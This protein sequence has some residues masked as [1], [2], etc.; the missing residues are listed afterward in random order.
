MI[1]I[2]G[3]PKH[4]VHIKL[5]MMCVSGDRVGGRA[6]DGKLK[7]VMKILSKNNYFPIMKTWLEVRMVGGYNEI[8]KKIQKIS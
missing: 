4:Y 8:G 7:L 2:W 6:K 1:G 5:V 3:T